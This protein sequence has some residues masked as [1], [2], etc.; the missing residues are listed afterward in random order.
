TPTASSSARTR[1]ARSSARSGSARRSARRP[2]STPPRC[3]RRSSARRCSSSA[4]VPGKT[5]SRWCSHACPHERRTRAAR[6][7]TSPEDFH[8]RCPKARATEPA[9]GAVS[10]KRLAFVLL[11]VAARAAAQDAATQQLLQEADR[12]YDTGD[13]ERAASNFDR[14]IRA[15]PKDVP[16]VAYAKRASIYLFAKRYDEGLRFIEDVAEKTW[17]EDDTILEQKAVMLSR[18]G[19]HKKEAVALAERVADRRP[20]AYTLQSLL[21]RYN[22]QLGAP[23]ARKTPRRYE[24]YLKFRPSDLAGQDSLVRVKLGFSYL[25]LGRFADAEKQLDEAART[26]DQVLAANARKGLCAAYAGGGNWDR[27]ITLCERVLDEKRALK[28]DPSPQ[29]N[30]GLAYLNRDRLDEGMKAADAYVAMRPKEAKGYPPRGEVFEKRN[31]LTDAEAQLNQANELAP[32]DGDV[33]R[34]LGRVYLRQKRAQKAIDKL[35]R[36][37]SARPN[38]AA[39][40]AVLAEAY[41]ADGQGQNAAQAAERGLRIPGQTQN[42]RFMALA[43]EGYYAAGQLTTARGILERAMAA[44]KAQGQASDARIRTL[45]VGTIKRPAGARFAAD[46]LAGAEKLLGEAKEVDPESTRTN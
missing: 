25:Y 34:E 30:A 38:D 24:A 43:A 8:G 1:P 31:K 33:A 18:Q 23:P 3:A 40:I 15:Q 42:P 22:Y 16:A 6:A 19:A 14:A 5:T 7:A 2:G 12:A 28:G 27:A 39:T 20:S 4:S 10:M 9:R 45:L 41:L 13:Y 46:D 29:Y 32:N 36:V 26:G 35:Q 44:S 17:P 11:L 21:G 37:A